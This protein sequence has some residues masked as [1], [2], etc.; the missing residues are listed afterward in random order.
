[1][2]ASSHVLISYSRQDADYADNVY[3]H[4]IQD[5]SVWMD[6]YSIT[7]G[8]RFVPAIRQA[9]R[10][11]YAIIVIASDKSSQSDWVE[12]EVLAARH[13]DKLII[14]VY[15][16][17]DTSDWFIFQGIQGINAWQLSPEVVIERIQNTLI[18]RREQH[19]TGEF[20]ISL[21]Q[22]SAK[23]TP[24]N[25]ESGTYI[26][27]AV[28]P[29]QDTKS[30]K[31]SDEKPKPQRSR[32]SK[33]KVPRWLVVGVI[34]LILVIVVLLLSGNIDGLSGTAGDKTDPTDVSGAETLTPVSVT[35]VATLSPTA[36]PVITP[37]VTATAVPSSPTPDPTE[38]LQPSATPIEVANALPEIW[39]APASNG[40]W[41][42]IE[43]E[44]A[45]IPM[46]LVPTGCFIMDLE[47][48]NQEVCF[49]ESF[50]LD[51][52]EVTRAEYGEVGN[53]DGAFP[54]GNITWPDARDFCTHRDI[55]NQFRLPTEA[56]WEYAARGPESWLYPWGNELSDEYI[57]MAND[58][59]QVLATNDDRLDDVSW[60][61]AYNLAGNYREWTNSIYRDGLYD[62]TDGRE[63]SSQS[64]IRVMRGGKWTE[65]SNVNT[66]VRYQSATGSVNIAPEL[67]FR[68]AR[69]Y[70]EGDLTSE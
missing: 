33:G 35:D 8:T 63:D 49:T 64:G 14:P 43:R 13:E 19:S 68:C 16:T 29:A 46:V 40:E 66:T 56:E 37:S 17:E 59:Y 57:Q 45:G 50:W 20:P 38:T 44:F 5:F 53:N 4:L 61:G 21:E 36:T 42:T 54:I 65:P 1:M 58:I 34:L 24:A 6:T 10:D 52:Y 48:Q 39:T 12:D 26:F 25:E 62:A 30:T 70:T 47:G 28:N 27:K 41:E 22:D 2:V 32:P 55:L 3:Q 18:Q 51:K 31:S 15:L 7:P 23:V 60:V 67:G 69:D 11:A 9:I